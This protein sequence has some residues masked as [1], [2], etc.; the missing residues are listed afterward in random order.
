MQR[1]SLDLLWK[2]HIYLLQFGLSEFVDPVLEV[3]TAGVF[4]ILRDPDERPLEADLLH[5]DLCKLQLSRIQP[6]QTWKVWLRP[7]YS[8]QQLGWEAELADLFVI[9][10][11]DRPRPIILKRCHPFES[12]E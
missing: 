2:A 1:K 11:E 6:M 7:H 9:V 8:L 12:G 3:C 5:V 10:L 4:L